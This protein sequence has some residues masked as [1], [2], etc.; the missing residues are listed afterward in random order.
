LDHPGGYR[1]AA[2]GAGVQIRLVA[3]GATNGTSVLENYGNSKG[4][5]II[6][7]SH[8]E[9][10]ISPPPYIVRSVNGVPDGFGDLSFLLKYRFLSG[11]EERGNYI[12]T[13]FLGASLSTGSYTNGV[14]DS[15]ITP[16]IAAGKGWGNFDV[17]STSVRFCARGSDSAHWTPVGVELC[18]SIS[19]VEQDL[20]GGGSELHVLFPRPQ[21]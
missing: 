1:R 19:S 3:P 16:T 15:T 17:T 21:R 14:K 20:A 10:I 4:L 11:N 9:I 5:E 12:L 7:P 13:A 2:P 6:R 8:T 18:R